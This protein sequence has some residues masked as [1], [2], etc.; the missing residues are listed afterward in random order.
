M[1][2]LTRTQHDAKREKEEEGGKKKK[3]ERGKNF[4]YFKILIFL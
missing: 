1:F 4:L 2:S 3:E